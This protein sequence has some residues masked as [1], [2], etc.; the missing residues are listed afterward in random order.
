MYQRETHQSVLA[1]LD[2]QA[3]VVLLGPRQVGKTTLALD[4][5]ATRPAVYLDLESDADRQILTEADL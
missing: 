2:S 1:A 4:I 3:A 5:A